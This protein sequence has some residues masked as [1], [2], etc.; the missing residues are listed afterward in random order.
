V[1]PLKI[2]D[3]ID[4]WIKDAATKELQI[5]DFLKNREILTVPD[6]MQHY[7]LR[8]MPEYLRPLQDFAS[9]VDFTSPSRLKDNASRYSTEP[10][11]NLGY[12]WR[13][14]AQDPQPLTV[15]EGIPRPLFPAL[16]FLET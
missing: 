15:H 14:T 12:F 11:P 8:A 10:S 9:M 1:P 3:N 16:S 2:A 6:W 7:T 13:A 4:N 5:R